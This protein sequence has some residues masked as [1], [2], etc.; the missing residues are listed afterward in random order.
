MEQYSILGH[1]GEGAHGIVFKAKQIEVMLLHSNPHSP[2]EQHHTLGKVQVLGKVCDELADGL[3]I[4]HD[5]SSTHSSQWN[6]N[7]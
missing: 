6:Q 3:T 7:Q 1:I 2:T 5:G 4:A